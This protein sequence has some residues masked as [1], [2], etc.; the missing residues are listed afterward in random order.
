MRT[1]M[2]FASLGMIIAFVIVNLSTN[3]LS[4][5]ADLSGLA[6]SYVNIKT[7]QVLCW[8][9]APHLVPWLIVSTDA[10]FVAFLGSY[11]TMLSPVAALMIYDYYLLRPGKLSYLIIL[12][13]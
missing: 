1:G 12:Q 8:F 11:T 9:V 13:Q 5:G 2:F 3:C 7:G 6:P 10:N 4:V